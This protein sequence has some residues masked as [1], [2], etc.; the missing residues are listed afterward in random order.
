[1]GHRFFDGAGLWNGELMSTKTPKAKEGLDREVV[2]AIG[3]VMNRFSDLNQFDDGPGHRMPFCIFESV[4]L[5]DLGVFTP[6]GQLPIN[7]LEGRLDI[8]ANVL[9]VKIRVFSDQLDL[10]GGALSLTFQ[11]GFVGP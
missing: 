9:D 3:Q 10:P 5:T 11:H 6:V 1:M 4:K 2:A 8:L 7:Q